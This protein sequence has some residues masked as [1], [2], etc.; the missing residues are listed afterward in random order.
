MELLA[1]FRSELYWNSY[2][3]LGQSY[4]G[5]LKVYY[6]RVILELLSFIIS[7]LNWNSKFFRSELYRTLCFKGFIGTTIRVI[8]ELLFFFYSELCR[9][10]RI[11]VILELSTH[12]TEV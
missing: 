3:L 12:L 1:S 5:T 6:L 8:L 2:V 10:L 4:I 9:T 11:E 7:E